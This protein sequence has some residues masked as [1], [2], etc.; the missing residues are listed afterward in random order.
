MINTSKSEYSE[1][2]KLR[3]EKLIMEKEGFA[4]E[5]SLRQK[6]LKLEIHLLEQ[7]IK[8]NES[9]VIAEL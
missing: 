1:E 4:I 6:K 9:T 3:I 5:T 2:S 8:N 7:Q